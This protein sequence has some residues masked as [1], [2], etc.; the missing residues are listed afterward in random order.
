MALQDLLKKAISGMQQAEQDV[1]LRI[2]LGLCLPDHL[3][4]L[5]Q[6]SSDK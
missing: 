1:L 5:M 3:K 6:F 4:A 2:Q